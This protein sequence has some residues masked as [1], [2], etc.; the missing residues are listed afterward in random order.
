[1][2]LLDFLR[3]TQGVRESSS[4]LP[5]WQ[6]AGLPSDPLAQPTNPHPP[7]SPEAAMWNQDNLGPRPVAN[8]PAALPAAAPAPPTFSAV[9]Q[10]LRSQT[11]MPGGGPRP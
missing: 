9:E 8:A 11:G 4:R 2:S 6:Q 10:L 7:G 1:M 3:P 5:S